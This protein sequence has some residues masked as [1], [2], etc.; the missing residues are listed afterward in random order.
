M[1]LLVMIY[2]NF[3]KSV[4]EILVR[5]MGERTLPFELLTSL[6]RLIPPCEE[7][8]EPKIKRQKLDVCIGSPVIS[9]S[10]KVAVCSALRRVLE[11]F[12][13]PPCLWAMLASG[14]THHMEFIL[15]VSR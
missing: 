15:L 8:V 9:L 7:G 4:V 1:D 13:P 3:L 5:D 12:P 11:G 6:E 10:D 2:C 14:S